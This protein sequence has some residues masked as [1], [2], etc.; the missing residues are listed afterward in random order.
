MCGL[1]LAA[2]V[3]GSRRASVFGWPVTVTPV[4]ETPTATVAGELIAVSAESL[5]VLPEPGLAGLPWSHVRQVT[6]RRHS[7]G[8]G[9]ALGWA[10]GGAVVTGA[11]L[12]AACSSVE[13][14]ECG[15]I[16]AG[17]ALS[18]LIVGGL[19]AASLQSSSKITFKSPSWDSLRVYARF[20]QGLP[21]SLDRQALVPRSK[22]A[23]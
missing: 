21:D 10:L 5:W 19:S 17:V 12:T 6:V 8:G 13:D 11:L 20:P 16:F 9:T 2:C 15:G 3:T 7:M 1:L 22:G 14:T 4:G 18:W 23:P